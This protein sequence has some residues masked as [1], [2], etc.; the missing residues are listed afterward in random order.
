MSVSVAAAT[1]TEL[2]GRRPGR[3]GRVRV[4]LRTR[5]AGAFALGALLISVLVAVVT[6]QVARST[7]VEPLRKS[8]IIQAQANARLVQSGLDIEPRTLLDELP[9]GEAKPALILPTGAFGVTNLPPKLVAVTLKSDVAWVID[10]SDI[11]PRLVVAVPLDGDAGTYF[12][13]SSLASVQRNLSQLANALI[14]AAS[15]TTVLGALVGSAVAAR[16]LLPVRQVATAATEIASGRLETRLPLLGDTDLD[17]L[18][19]SFNDMAKS[20]QSR[21]EREARFASDVSH[22]LRTPLTALSA[23]AQLLAARRDELPERSQTALDVLVTQ[24]EHFR[25]L[26]LDLLEISRI[27]AGAADVHFEDLDLGEL[28]AQ[29][30][31]T[32]GF[33][34]PLDFSELD[35]HVMYVDKRRVERI[36]TNLLQNA[37]NYAGAATGVLLRNAPPNADGRRCVQLVVDDDGPGVAEADRHRIFDRFTRGSVMSTRPG[38]KGTG[39]GLS[40]VSEHARLHGGG[41]AW[42]ETSPDG[43][44]RFVVELHETSHP[45]DVESDVVNGSDTP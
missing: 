34:V 31:R 8:A 44:A 4:G 30:I 25:R 5:T 43:G 6:Y 36:L 35:P 1:A 38:I 22:E 26:V 39:L 41:R 27:D 7:F 29:I 42:V 37:Q 28:C 16:V 33:D 17:P 32:A 40:L 13:V 24:T 15:I 2:P 10:D 20:L 14:V 19:S 23:A 11:G 3:W 9:K 21:L 45:I 18:L 12:E